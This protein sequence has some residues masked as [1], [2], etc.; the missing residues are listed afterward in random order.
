MR[1]SSSGPSKSLQLDATGEGLSCVDGSGAGGLACGRLGSQGADPFVGAGEAGFRAVHKGL[2]FRQLLS[3][4][5][6]QLHIVLTLG[7]SRVQTVLFQHLVEVSSIAAGK[8]SGTRDISPR[9][10]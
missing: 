1:P 8:L 4:R 10:L 5:F 6:F 7:G 9:Q 3:R 2:H